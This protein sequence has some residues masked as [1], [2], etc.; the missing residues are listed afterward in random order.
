MTSDSVTLTLETK[1]KS[2]NLKK[3]WFYDTVTARRI[4][5]SSLQINQTVDEL[6][7]VK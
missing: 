5:M 1:N 4:L 7:Q 6:T 3:H 2:D